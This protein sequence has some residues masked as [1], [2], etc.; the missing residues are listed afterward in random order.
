MLGLINP[1]L[2]RLPADQVLSDCTRRSSTVTAAHHQVTLDAPAKYNDSCSSSGDAGRP[3]EVHCRAD[4]VR[5]DV[6]DELLLRALEHDGVQRPLPQ[7]PQLVHVRRLH[8]WSDAAAQPAAAGCR[9]RCCCCRRRLLLLEEACGDG[10]G[11]RDSRDSATSASAASAASSATAPGIFEIRTYVIKPEHLTEYLQVCA[12]TAS[13]RRALN[14]G[15]LGLWVTEVGNLTNQVTHMYHYADYDA[16]DATRAAMGK[17]GRWQDFLKATKPHLV[18]QLSE[19]F[20]P[21]TTALRA[22][23]IT[24]PPAEH[25]KAMARASD[26]AKAALEAACDDASQ[27]A[28]EASAAAAAQGVFEIRT[29]QLELGYNPIPKLVA[30]MEDG[31]PSK[32]ASDTAKLGQLVFMGWSDVGKLN[33]FVEL[34]RYPTCQ[35]H[36]RVREAAR[37]A[38]KWRET[39]GL[40]APMVQMFDT[41]LVKSAACSPIK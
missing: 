26:A 41:R 17:D 31:L 3:R 5:L 21:A 28:A 18:S 29:Y 23:G 32:M 34:W 1:Q 22:A 38:V 12:E 10:N 30:H 37:T 25:M 24:V 6:G 4:D 35:D 7:L 15:F 13:V 33:Q 8:Q 27:A 39:I 2:E 9:R 11:A 16:R 19:I 20:L 14:P 36:I 40:I